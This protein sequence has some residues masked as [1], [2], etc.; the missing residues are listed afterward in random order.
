[1]GCPALRRSELARLEQQLQEQQRHNQELK[2]S[3]RRLQ[4]D[5][6]VSDGM[7]FLMAQGEEEPEPEAGPQ[8]LVGANV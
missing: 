4:R 8:D 1:M 5:V 6:E 3:V 2:D 7:L